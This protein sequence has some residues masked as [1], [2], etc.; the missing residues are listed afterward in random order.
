MIKTVPIDTSSL[1]DV[2]VLTGKIG[3]KLLDQVEASV[4]VLTESQSQSDSLWFL[5]RGLHYT[6]TSGLKFVHLLAKECPNDIIGNENREHLYNV[7]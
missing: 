7:I 4:R 3:D 5:A 2:A 6:S 1:S